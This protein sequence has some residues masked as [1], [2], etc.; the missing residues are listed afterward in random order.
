[1][2]I[3]KKKTFVKTIKFIKIRSKKSQSK[4]KINKNNNQIFLVTLK[5]RIHKKTKNFQK[6]KF[7][8][9]AI[10]LNN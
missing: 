10:L 2:R 5:M 9:K 6:N 8:K 1:M 3:I 4:N 7:Q